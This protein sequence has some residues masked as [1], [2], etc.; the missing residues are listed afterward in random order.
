MKGHDPANAFMGLGRFLKAHHIAQ[1]AI[2]DHD[3]RLAGDTEQVIVDQPRQ[4]LIISCFL[5]VFRY[6]TLDEDRDACCVLDARSA[7]SNYST[8]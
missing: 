6:T 2:V 7:R 8:R 3:G 4:H 5:L 1:Q